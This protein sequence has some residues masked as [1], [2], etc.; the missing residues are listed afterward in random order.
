MLQIEKTYPR[1]DI[2]PIERRSHGLSPILFDIE[3]TGLSAASSIIYLIGAIEIKKDRLVFRQWFA[4]G[5]SDELKVLE[6]FLNFLPDRACLVSF[7]GRGFDVPFISKRCKNYNIPC[8]LPQLPDIDLYRALAPLK[9]YFGMNSRKLVSYEKLIG[10]DR[11]DKYNGGELIEVYKEYVGKRK[12]APEEAERLMEMLLLHNEEDICDMVPVTALLTYIDLLNADIENISGVSVNNENSEV[13]I[14]TGLCSDFPI[15]FEKKLATKPGLPMINIETVG[16][17]AKIHI[18]VFNGRL[19]HYFEDYKDYF[20]L[21]DEDTAIHK[22][23]AESVDSSH[24][25][26]ATKATAYTWANGSFI[27]QYTNKITPYFKCDINDMLSFI[28]VK[29]LNTDEQV[30]GYIKTLS[31]R[32]S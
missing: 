10:L 31:N 28:P 22:S 8:Y 12:F 25:V 21:P 17:C 30:L 29:S 27:P 16:R 18:P 9:D 4:E 7:N 24:R 20:Y 15:S 23:I 6:S 3:T 32:I 14:E 26:Q 13:I 11:E 5:P 19:K 1:G 2:Y